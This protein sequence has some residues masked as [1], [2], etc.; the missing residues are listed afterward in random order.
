MARG[1]APLTRLRR[2]ACHSSVT[3]CRPARF[4]GSHGGVSSLPSRERNEQEEVGI[5]ALV[6][7]A[8]AVITTGPAY[9]TV[10]LAL[11]NNN[12]AR[13][14]RCSECSECA[15]RRE[16]GGREQRSRSDGAMK[17]WALAA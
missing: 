10:L 1:T 6:D 2:R 8:V 16:P 13:A 12:R 17:T 9:L 7:I 5:V 11:R 15:T 3:E 14:R 4:W